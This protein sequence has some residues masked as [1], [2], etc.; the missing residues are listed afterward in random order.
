MDRPRLFDEDEYHRWLR[1]AEDTL[2]SAGHDLQNGH[3]NWSCFK[4]QQAAEYAAKALLRGLGQRATGHSILKLLEELEGLGPAITGELKT[5]AR[6]L[7]RHYIP[8]RYPNAFAAGSPY[9]FY[10][11]PTARAAMAAADKI[12][13]FIREEGQKLA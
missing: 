12:V 1:Q 4:S 3:C 8:P 2:G 10:D 7:D 11:E 5:H 6:T 13:E 9:E